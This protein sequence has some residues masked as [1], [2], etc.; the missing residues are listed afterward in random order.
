M[1]RRCALEPADDRID[2]HHDDGHGERPQFPAHSSD[3]H[4]GFRESETITGFFH[5]DF[6]CA[7]Y[8]TAKRL[9]VNFWLGDCGF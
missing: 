9:Q 8:D 2:T 5:W 6:G 1:H 3:H 4:G 7:I